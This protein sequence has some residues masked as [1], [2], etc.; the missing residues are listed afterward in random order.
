MSNVSTTDL[1]TGCPDDIQA[2]GFESL[3]G[4]ADIINPGCKI[5]PSYQT[6]T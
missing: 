3:E 1:L 2:P 5:S 4:G 6:P